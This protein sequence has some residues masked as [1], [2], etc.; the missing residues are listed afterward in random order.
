MARCT[1]LPLLL[2]AALAACST[3]NLASDGLQLCRQ[4]SCRAMGEPGREDLA[5]GLYQLFQAASGKDLVLSE[6]KPGSAEFRGRGI[7]VFTQGGP[8]PAV[9]KGKALHVTDV[10]YL[11]LGEGVIKFKARMRG[12]F[13]F[14][15]VLCAEGTGT[16]RI[17]SGREARLELSNLCTWLGPTSYWKLEG[18]LDRVDV[19][20][21]VVG[22]AY[23][24]HGGGVPVVGGGSGYLL[25]K[26]GAEEAPET[27]KRPEP[28]APKLPSVPVPSLPVPALPVPPLPVPSLPTPPAP[29]APTPVEAM[30]ELA[31]APVATLSAKLKEAGGDSVIDAGEAF[32][33]TVELNNAGLA[34]AKN[35]R[36]LLSGTP[37]L[38]A[39]L[40]AER[41]LGD[42]PAGQAT[43]SE[44]KGVL[45]PTTP[46]QA[47]TL[48]VEA[49]SDPGGVLLG[50]KT[51]R[52]ALRG[53]LEE[54]A[55]VLSE[56]DVDEIPAATKGVGGPDD[57]ALVVG[58]SRYRDKDIPGV[59]YAARD[60][61]LVAKYLTRVAG[62]PA[63]NVKVLTDETATKSDFEAYL[64][65]WLPRRVNERSRVFVY[66]AGHGS[67]AATAGEAFLV[68]YEGQP[69]FPSKLLPLKSLM[70]S[71]EKLPAR[72]V[73]VA[74][75][76]C[77]SGAAGR[78]IL[79]SG[80][81]PLVS[82][83]E[84][85]IPADRKLVVLSA[86]S[87]SQ[88]SSDYDKAR[89]GLFT[90]ALLRG[91]RGEADSDSSGAVTVGEL[92]KYVREQVGKRASLELNRD[93]TPTL[94]P[95]EPVAGERLGIRLSSTRPK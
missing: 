84:T 62:V 4:G 69:D 12:T 46:S 1:A 11:D 86:A 26:I 65:D 36:L 74:L 54:A 37:A 57:A 16:V 42:L 90:Y 30:E 70:A 5:R 39:A 7:R 93:Q 34:A 64:T 50:A 72:E 21:G 22:F 80:A 14:V 61:E 44:V 6:E 19:D 25:A 92:Y 89:H 48:R 95:S 85:P 38:T 3:K 53:R 28:K 78:G 71:L 27:E 67:P 35:V 79:P 23:G 60:A 40:G 33:L 91:L 63:E 17:L 66:F 49:V 59:R 9:Y 41:A 83:V 8:F 94:N 31:S 55:E 81:R 15:P 47:G 10:L 73:V 56:L 87:G 75:D 52:V 58:I 2:L 32:G 20:G 82:T 88:V 13:L 45:A 29:S 18:A 51:F 68:P 24:L 77:F 76:S 43:A